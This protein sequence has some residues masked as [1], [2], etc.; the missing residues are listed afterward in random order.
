MELNIHCNGN[1]IQVS[2]MLLFKCFQFLSTIA[3]D[4]KRKLSL[5]NGLFLQIDHV[6]AFAQSSGRFD[7]T[8]G[9]I[10][11]LFLAR[12]KLLLDPHIKVYLLS[13]D[14]LSW[15]LN[16]G[17]HEIIVPKDT[18]KYKR[19]WCS[20]IPFGEPCKYVTTTGLKWNLGKTWITAFFFTLQHN[21][22]S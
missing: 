11:S 12:D 10:Q 17:E 5:K 19:A 14:S 21:M 9:N 7:Q 4:Y 22:L 16:P 2:Y 1:E 13:D 20:L 3:S 8:I 18:L 15:L 6:I